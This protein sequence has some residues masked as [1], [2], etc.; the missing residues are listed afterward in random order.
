MKHLLFILDTFHPEYASTGQI[1]TELARSLQNDF[2]IT[3]IV[4]IPKYGINSSNV[5]K[6]KNFYFE[7]FENISIV[8]VKTPKLNKMSKISRFKFIVGHFL[9]AF[10]AV[11]KVNKPDLTFVISQPPI[12]GGVLGSL[13][14]LFRGGKLIYNIQD[15]NPEQAATIGYNKSKLVTK[16]ARWVD[17]ASIMSADRV[18]V[19]GR[20]MKQQLF[21]RARIDESKVLVI[22]NWID[23]QIVKPHSKK[24]KDVKKYIDLYGLEGKLTFMYSG[25]IGLYYDLQ[26]II[27]IIGKFNKLENVLFVF[28]GGGAE[29]D[30]LKKYSREN[31]LSNVKFFP[32]VAKEEVVYSL[33]AADIHFVTNHKG[34]KGISVPSKIYGIMAVGKPVLGIIETE[35]EVEMLIRD[36]GC[37]RVVEPQDYDGIEKLIQWYIDTVDD[38]EDMGSKGR[39]YLEVHNRK[40]MS[41][42][43]YRN[44]LTEI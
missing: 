37:G 30:Q 29:L 31:N 26:N 39:E 25:N 3:V 13:T 5:Y 19:V 17:N 7:K 14:K 27:K 41:I 10:R 12:L 6:G 33:S 11:F 22:N 4:G 20:D 28:V 2:R 23:E 15:F 38:I 8:R 36:S 24:H 32:Y 34:I 18:V 44:M 40:V 43:K 16:V 42:E 9:N 21:K 35:S 1:M